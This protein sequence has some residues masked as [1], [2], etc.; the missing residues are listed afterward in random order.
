VVNFCYGR[1]SGTLT[2]GTKTSTPVDFA[3]AKKIYDKLVKEKTSKGYTPDVSGATYQGTENAGLKS[4]FIP[5]LL[6][7]ISE[8]EAMLLIKDNRWAVQE[9]MDGERRAVHAENGNVIGMNRKGLIVPLP[10]G[11][12]DE[13]QTIATRYGAILVDGEIIGDILYVFDLHVYKGEHIHSLPW[14]ERMRLVEFALAG[15]NWVRPVPV[16]VTTNE[17]RSL[18]NK[19]KRDHGEGVVL[20]LSHSIVKQ[21]RPNSGG[22]WLKYKFTESASCY[23]MEVNSGKRSVKIGLLDSDR[24]I[25]VGNVT[26]PPNQNVPAAGDVV[27]VEYLYAYKGGSIYQP[28]YRGKRSDLDISACIAGQLKYKPEGYEEEELP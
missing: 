10:Q 24:I 2:V 20:K 9:K 14:I 11:I 23:V 22:D 19:V 1:R 12:A 4:D 27:E 7:P 28:V 25:S 21:G 13:L 15:C 5:Q 17:K 6:N 16:A 18:W 3:Q 8:D 26:I